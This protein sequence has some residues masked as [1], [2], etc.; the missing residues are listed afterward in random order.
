[1]KALGGLEPDERRQA[2]QALNVVK[3]EIGVALAERQAVLKRAELADKLVSETIDVSLPARA[4]ADGRT[5]PL[6]RTIEQISA[7]F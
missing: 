2:G 6:S 1:M 5:H 3:E 4:T 7:I